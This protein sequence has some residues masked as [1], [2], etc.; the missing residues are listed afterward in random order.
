[1]NVAALIEAL[2]TLPPDME[3]VVW[4]EPTKSLRPVESVEDWSDGQ[5]ALYPAP[6][7]DT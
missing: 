4:D 5:V 3:V 2:A 6:R 1:M 7:D